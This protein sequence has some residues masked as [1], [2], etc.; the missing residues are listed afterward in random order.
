[1]EGCKM[2]YIT[3]NGNGLQATHFTEGE[4]ASLWHNY[5][6]DNKPMIKC[7]HGSYTNSMISKRLLGKNDSLTDSSWSDGHGDS[8]G[9]DHHDHS[10]GIRV[11]VEPS[12]FELTGVIDEDCLIVLR[13]EVKFREEGDGLLV[14]LGFNGF[15]INQKGK[16]IIEVVQSTRKVPFRTFKNILSDIGVEEDAG[17][18]FIQKLAV[19]GLLSLQ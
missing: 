2:N 16:E 11:D 9:P 6:K 17:I 1:M 19:F 3:L 8:R 5:N 10:S 12:N 15:F 18:S 7:I 14:A 13:D 4:L